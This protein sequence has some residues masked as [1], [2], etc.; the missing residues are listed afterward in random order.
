MFD[1]QFVHCVAHVG[2]GVDLEMNLGIKQYEFCWISYWLVRTVGA[3]EEQ[4]N[5]NA[6]PGIEVRN[7]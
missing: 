1:C 4:L 3:Q 6:E 7:R 2:P 5:P